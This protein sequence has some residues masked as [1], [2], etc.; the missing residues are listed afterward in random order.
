ML[1]VT[2]L[3]LFWSPY[4]PIA[5][6][7]CIWSTPAE[8]ERAAFC[9]RTPCCF[10]PLFISPASFYFMLLFVVYLVILFLHC[11]IIVFLRFIA[12]R[13]SLTRYNILPHWS[14]AED[15][16]NASELW[17]ILVCS[18]L[19]GYWLAWLT[20]RKVPPPGYEWDGMCSVSPP[21]TLFPEPG[22]YISWMSCTGGEK[23]AEQARP[24]SLLI[25]IGNL[26]YCV[27]L[28]GMNAWPNWKP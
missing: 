21:P 5:S 9:C 3:I 12:R 2:I 22:D 6:G 13:G 10:Y 11:L 24:A 26:R 18:S 19:A 23:W 1:V 16:N 27:T 20:L 28:C 14:S 17:H 4:M 8:E 7:N 25:F 15:S